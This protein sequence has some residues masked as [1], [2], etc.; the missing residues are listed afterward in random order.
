MIINI[1][2]PQLIE[3]FNVPPHNYQAIVGTFESLGF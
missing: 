2:A 1:I 3:D